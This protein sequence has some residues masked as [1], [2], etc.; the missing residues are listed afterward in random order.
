MVP[1]VLSKYCYNS[2]FCIRLLL[3][4]YVV[5]CSN[6]VTRTRKADN[7]HTTRVTRYVRRCAYNLS[8]PGGA[9]VGGAMCGAVRRGLVILICVKSCVTCSEPRLGANHGAMPRLD[10]TQDISGDGAERGALAK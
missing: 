8:E 7:M 1:N 5:F 10:P 9:A 4:G 2:Q 3:L 6:H